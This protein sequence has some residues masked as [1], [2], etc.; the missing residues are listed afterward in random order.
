VADLKREQLQKLARMGA[1]ARLEELQR[2]EAA[3]RRAFPDLSG[4][5]RAST[6]GR[7]SNRSSG[8]RPMSAA[9][10][11]AVSERMKRYWADRRKKA[12]K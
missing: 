4:T 11:K 10:R 7:R 5:G 9:N 2:E 6:T 1:R 12:A 3:I 8:R